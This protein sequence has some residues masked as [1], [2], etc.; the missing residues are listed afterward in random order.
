MNVF[1]K[2]KRKTVYLLQVTKNYLKLFHNRLLYEYIE[3][4]W[5]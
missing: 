3:N 1:L 2:L 5:N 4:Q